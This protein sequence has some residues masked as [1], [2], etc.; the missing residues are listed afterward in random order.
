MGMRCAPHRFRPTVVVLRHRQIHVN[1]CCR[2]ARDQRFPS[3]RSSSLDSTLEKPLKV[4]LKHHT[5]QK[6]GIF[7]VGGLLTV[8]ASRGNPPYG[9]KAL[10]SVV[11]PPTSAAT[12]TC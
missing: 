7:G 12:M 11:L 2:R 1:T 10:T 6:H 9:N 4:S 8:P 3:R 5:G